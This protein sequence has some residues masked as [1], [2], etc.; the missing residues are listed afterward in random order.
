MTILDRRSGIVI[1]RNLCVGRIIGTSKVDWS[2]TILIRSEGLVA[3]LK[4]SIILSKIVLIISSTS[5]KVVTDN[6]L[7][8]SGSGVTLK[9]DPDTRPLLYVA[10]GNLLTLKIS[11]PSSSLTT[12]VLMS[13]L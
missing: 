2:T 10:R 4:V 1:S 12:G 13:T 3:F 7:R 6:E 9:S 8:N 11:L 5:S